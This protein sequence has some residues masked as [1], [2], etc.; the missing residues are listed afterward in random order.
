MIDNQ[1]KFVDVD[2]SS[3]DCN[4]SIAWSLLDEDDD[5]YCPWKV[6]PWIWVIRLMKEKIND[7]VRDCYSPEEKAKLFPFVDFDVSFQ[8]HVLNVCF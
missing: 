3:M 2:N 4:Q 6:I 8:K 5:Y 7:S 1:E